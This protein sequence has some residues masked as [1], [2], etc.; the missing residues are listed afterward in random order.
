MSH[1][2]EKLLG[3]FAADTLTPEEKQHLFQAALRNQALFTMLADEQALKELLADP[4]IRRRL[5]QSLQATNSTATDAP[6]SWLDWI[7][8]P[9]GLAWAGG[10]AGA[11][12]AV[13]LGTSLYQESLRQETHSTPG[14]EAPAPA[15]SEPVPAPP[16]AATP[17]KNEPLG[18]SPHKPHS[19]PPPLRE[20]FTDKIPSQASPSGATQDERRIHRFE[21]DAPAPRAKAGPAKKQIDSSA[22]LSTTSIDESSLTAPASP[23][24]SQYTADSTISSQERTSLSARSLF[25]GTGPQDQHTSM[26]QD[27]RRREKTMGEPGQSPDRSEITTHPLAMAKS[28]HTSSLHPVGIRYRLTHKNQAAPLQEDAAD[29]SAPEVPRE[30]TVESNQDGF[31][32]VWKHVGTSEPQLLFPITD[33]EQS[34]AKLSAHTGLT[35]SIPST[36]GLLV[37]RFSR[38]APV[39]LT[40]FDQ[41]LLDE[42]SQHHL[43]ESVMTDETSRLSPPTHYI[44][45]QDPSL[46]EIVVLVSPTQP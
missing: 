2:L 46:S 20:A 23:L 43:R 13:V 14:E 33:T 44:V 7:G 3:G 29:T 40:S 38:T 5:L 22:E 19:S 45:N 41:T 16:Q 36:P 25:Y 1:E 35:I 27:T 18:I 6:S 34:R 4:I 17:P 21:R 12:L 37:L 10:L 39:P 15:A 31:L 32:Q 30:L 42:S 8:H 9:Y 11:V 24:P 28:K 26:A